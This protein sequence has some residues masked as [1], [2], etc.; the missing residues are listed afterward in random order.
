MRKTVKYSKSL[1]LF[2]HL[3][4]KILKY[5]LQEKVSITS[6]KLRVR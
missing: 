1:N 4:I 5:S 3:D 2:L 6:S